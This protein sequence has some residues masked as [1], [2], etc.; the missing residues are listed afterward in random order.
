MGRGSWVREGFYISSLTRRQ[1]PCAPAQPCKL[2]FTGSI[3]QTRTLSSEMV[4]A[5]CSKGGLWP[6]EGWALFTGSLQMPRGA[7]LVQKH[8]Q[9]GNAKSVS[10]ALSQTLPRPAESDPHVNGPT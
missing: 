2:G 6:R 5:H 4:K 7:S 1:P 10:N 9:G 3:S 8:H